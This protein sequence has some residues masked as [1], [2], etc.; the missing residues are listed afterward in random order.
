MIGFSPAS[1]APIRDEPSSRRVPARSALLLGLGRLTPG[2]IAGLEAEGIHTYAA[3]TPAEARKL[4][5]MIGPELMLLGSADRERGWEMVHEL[6]G[7]CP[8]AS[9]LFLLNSADPQEALRVLSAGADDVVS[10]PHTVATVLLRAHLLQSRK[11][12]WTPEQGSGSGGSLRV[13]RLSRTLTHAQGSTPLTGREFELLERL[14]EAGGQVVPRED[15][16][17]DIWGSDQ[18]SEAVL[19]ATVH[20]LRKKLERDPA[21]PDILTTVRGIGY[22]VEQARVEIADA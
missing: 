14:V 19:D 22:R 8:R 13:E 2:F 11:A 5:E 10:P 17:R 4:A 18:D 15:L 21:S 7:C 1:P 16:L 12:G 20:R 9:I 3:E 6:R